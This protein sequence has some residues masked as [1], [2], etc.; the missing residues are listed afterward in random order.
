MTL[1]KAFYSLIF[2]LEAVEAPVIAKLCI[3]NNSVINN[4]CGRLED[5]I[6]LSKFP[7]GTRKD[8]EVCR[9]FGHTSSKS[10]ASPGLVAEYIGT[11]DSVRD[12]MY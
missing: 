7:I 12:G 9:Q 10:F 3:N 5:L 6:F 1:D 4:N 2:K 8:F 11:C